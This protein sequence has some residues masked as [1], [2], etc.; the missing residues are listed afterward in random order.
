MSDNK[1]LYYRAFYAVIGLIAFLFLGLTYAWSVFVSPL[2]SE[3]GW[4]RSQTSLAFS[5]CMVALCLGALASGFAAKKISSRFVLACSA[6]FIFAGFFLASRLTSITELY[7]FYGALCGFGVGMGYNSVMSNVLKWF[8]DKIGIISGILLMGYGF[9]GTLL[10]YFA[11]FMINAKGW[12][13]TFFVLGITLAVVVVLAAL[14]LRSPQDGDLPHN[15]REK[16]MGSN[17]IPTSRMVRDRSFWGFFLWA[18]ILSAAGLAVIGNAMPMA[19]SIAGNGALVV[20]AA[21]LVNICNGLGRLGF[22]FLFDLIGSKRCFYIITAGLLFSMLALLAA[23]FTGSIAA[24]CVGF[25]FTGLSFGGVTPCNSAF[26][27]K[28]YGQ[29][30]YA[31]NFSIVTLELL[32]APFLGPYIAGL[33]QTAFG[34]YSGMLIIMAIL[35]IASAPCLLFIIRFRESPQI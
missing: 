33:A 7:V 29:K 25:V 11:V 12:R 18:T 31:T 27:S 9:G 34:G 24:L 5:I 14:L 1:K 8:P 6:L 22:G 10:G 35:C 23:C 15:S 26:V 19:N 32:I 30:Y 2:E 3:F 16:K 13:I 21:G 17:D 4:L 20:F 28:T